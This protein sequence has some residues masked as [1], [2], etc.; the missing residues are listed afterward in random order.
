[1]LRSYADVCDVCYVAYAT[2]ALYLLTATVRACVQ[3]CLTCMCGCVWV[4]T[5]VFV[6]VC[7]VYSRMFLK[8]QL[9]CVRV[10]VCVCVCVLAYGLEEATDMCASE[11]QLNLDTATS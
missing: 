9:T 8:K 5:C 2:Y 4:C 10:C 7:V 3:M 1:M 11:Q 6:C